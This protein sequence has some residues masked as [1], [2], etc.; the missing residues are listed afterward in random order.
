MPARQKQVRSVALIRDLVWRF[1]KALKAWK[2]RPSPQA[3]RGF[4]Q[5]FDRIF[6]FNTGYALL[7]RLRRR[8]HELL[9]VL[10]RPEIPLH[11]NASENDLRTFV[12]KRKISGGTMSRDGRVA[13]DV[14]PGL[15]KT[16]Q[17]LG[18]P[19]TTISVTGLVSA[20]SA[21]RFR[22]CRRSFS[23][24]LKH[25]GSLRLGCATTIARYSGTATTSAP[26]TPLVRMRTQQ[27]D[28]ISSCFHGGW[29]TIVNRSWP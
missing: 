17:S 4:H 27:F 21:N 15:M 23:L 19:F 2:Q 20:T 10:E 22:P 16:C 14:M 24:G 6:A 12:I 11:T 9:R 1:Y 18:C 29:L 7:A 5:R 13:R 26:R 3:V 28:H 8:K 25:P